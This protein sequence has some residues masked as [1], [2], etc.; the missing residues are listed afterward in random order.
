MAQYKHLAW[1]AIGYSN[2]GGLKPNGIQIKVTF[3][4]MLLVFMLLLVLVLKN[5]LI[6][7]IHLEH[8]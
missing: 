1:L 4:Q 6:S 8:L 5:W 7:V 3:M 2:G